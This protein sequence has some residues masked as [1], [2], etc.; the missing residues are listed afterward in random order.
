MEKINLYFYKCIDLDGNI[1]KNKIEAPNKEYVIKYLQKN[2]YLIIYIKKVSFINRD[3]EDLINIKRKMNR[4]ELSMFC[5]QMA[6]F[7]KSGISITSGLDIF[8]K[9]VKNKFINSEICRIKNKILLGEKLSKCL[10]DSNKFP[11]LLS[12]MIKTGEISGK[13][14]YIMEQMSNY[15]E[16]QWRLEEEVKNILI[17]PIIVFISMILV[18]FVFFIYVIPN[19]TLIF[20]TQDIY[21]PIITQILINT[22]SFISTNIKIIIIFC[23][24]AFFICKIFIPNVYKKNIKDILYIKSPFLGKFYIKLINLRFIQCFNIMLSSGVSILEIITV[25]KEVMNNSYTNKIMDQ[26]YNDI[27]YGTSI[28]VA[29]KKHKLFDSLLVG[30]ILTGENTG[31]LLEMLN[32]SNIFLE[33]DINRDIKRFE[34]L[35]EPI[36]TIFLGILLGIIMLAIILPMFSLMNSI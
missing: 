35:I 24:S 21:L 25:T 9:Q 13:M 30:M 20:E 7:F 27:K 32:K 19:Y 26:V 5:S 18:I 31:N 22:S 2:N 34:K 11:I 28:N 8:N 23:V 12:N 17:Y 10:L 29:L 36:I 1:L 16:K 4:K 15:Y 33:E 14:P 3:I 6:L